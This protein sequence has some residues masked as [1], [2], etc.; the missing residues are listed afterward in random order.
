[1]GRARVFLTAVAIGAALATGCGD[2]GRP[3]AGDVGTQGPLECPDVIRVDIT[4][5]AD[6]THTIAA[7][8]SSPYETVDHFVNAITV[9]APAGEEL[10]RLDLVEAHVDQQP[11]TETLT[12]VEIEPSMTEVVVRGHDSING[13]C[14]LTIRADVPDAP[15]TDVEE[16]P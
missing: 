1:M 6:G 8:V 16:G 10:A 9:Q 12:G 15:A 13:W 3:A 11:F 2:S 14:G 5:D 4:R 7:T